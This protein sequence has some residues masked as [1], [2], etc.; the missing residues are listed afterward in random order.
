MNFLSAVP[1]AAIF[2][3]GAAALV[4]ASEIGHYVGTKQQGEANVSTLEASV[5]GLLALMLGF[6]FSMALARY[7]ERRVAV[8]NAANAIGTA[9]LR[10]SLLPSPHDA[11][12]LKL[13]RDYV[14]VRI[15]LAK[16]PPTPAQIETALVRSNELQTAFWRQARAAL[17]KDNSMAPTGLYIQALN[18]TFDDQ[19]K[20]LTAGRAHVPDIVLLSLYGV[21]VVAM[22]FS[23]FASGLE[24]RRWRMPVYV[25]A[26]LVASVI[27]LI[28]DIDRPDA[29]FVG[30]SQ[31]PMF[32]AA[33]QIAGLTRELSKPP[34]AEPRGLM[35]GAPTR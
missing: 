31:Q 29:G 3:V 22:A 1:L 10:A 2:V 8:L 23:G 24:G 27:L 30:V 11:E 7:E 34:A 33:A 17:A 32:D 14:A 21:A 25:T 26:L 4:A 20:R 6:T 9:A 5:L 18:E 15:D 12:S 28:Q 35:R 16:A 19:E 13:F